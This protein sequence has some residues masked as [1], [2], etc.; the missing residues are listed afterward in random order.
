M[1]NDKMDAKAERQ[2]FAK[3]QKFEPLYGKTKAVCWRS[4]SAL[5]EIFRTAKIWSKNASHGFITQPRR[6]TSMF[7]KAKAYPIDHIGVTSASVRQPHSM[8]K[9]TRSPEV[10][11]TQLVLPKPLLPRSIRAISSLVGLM[12]EAIACVLLPPWK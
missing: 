4:C 1:Q 3:R 5:P 11:S 10:V 7:I 9:E 12:Q 2:E 6:A 8:L